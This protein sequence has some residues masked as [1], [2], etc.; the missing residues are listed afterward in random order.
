MRDRRTLTETSVARLIVIVP[1]W[2]RKRVAAEAKRRGVG[3]SV[4]CTDALE[5]YLRRLEGNNCL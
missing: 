4:L 1:R 5:T 3:Y 2:L